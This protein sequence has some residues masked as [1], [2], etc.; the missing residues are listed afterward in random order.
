[1]GTKARWVGAFDPG[2]ESDTGDSEGRVTLNTAL[3]IIEDA[4]NTFV[5]LVPHKGGILIV[6]TT[7]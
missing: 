5:A 2:N 7:P 1:M 6:Y 3:K 4:G